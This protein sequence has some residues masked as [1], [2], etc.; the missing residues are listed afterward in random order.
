MSFSELTKANCFDTEYTAALALCNLFPTKV[1]S[2]SLPIC[3]AILIEFEDL[4]SSICFVV[5]ELKNFLF[6]KT[7]YQ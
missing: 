7:S 2:S 5:T 3:L 6:L 4:S 1:L